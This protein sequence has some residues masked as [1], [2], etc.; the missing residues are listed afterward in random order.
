MSTVS[1]FYYAPD[2]QLPSQ[3]DILSSSDILTEKYGRKVVGVGGHFVV[4]YGRNVDLREGEMMLWVATNT[5]IP[6]PRV[7]A[8]YWE[9]VQSFVVMANVPGKT[10]ARVWAGLTE[11][12]NVVV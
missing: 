3:D 4:K 10:L 11:D 8:L 12:Q 7:C 1:I 9:G 6:A 2:A 5:S